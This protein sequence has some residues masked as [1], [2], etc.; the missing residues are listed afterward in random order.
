MSQR[1]T[2][3]ESDVMNM[4]MSGNRGARLWWVCRIIIP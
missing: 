2:R 4:I 3:V 1:G